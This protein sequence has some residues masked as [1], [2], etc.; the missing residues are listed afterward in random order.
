MLIVAL[1][2]RRE[3]QLCGVAL[4]QM[5]GFPEERRDLV[6]VGVSRGEG[7][8]FP[9]EALDRMQV[10]GIFLTAHWIGDDALEALLPLQPDP[11]ACLFVFTLYGKAE[12]PVWFGFE[13]ER[14]HGGVSAGETIDLQ[15][16]FDITITHN[17][18]GSLGGV[19]ADVCAAL[20][21][22]D[23]GSNALAGCVGA[24]AF[25]VSLRGVWGW[26]IE[27]TTW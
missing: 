11:A 22:W 20:G 8:I 10:G 14:Q 15:R 16:R 19:T 21:Q 23:K 6:S 7:E 4:L 24:L 12:E 2:L 26:P 3:V 1:Q 27:L 17:N 13:I 5:V 25:H 18:G 9:Q